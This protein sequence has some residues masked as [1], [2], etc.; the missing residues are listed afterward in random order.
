MISAAITTVEEDGVGGLSVA[1][2][3]SGARVSR[4]TF[5][6]I[7]EDAEDCFLACF[8]QSV[9]RA[10]QI[11]R[12]AY[13]TGSDWRSSTRAAV[14]GLLGAMERQRALTRLCIV[15]VLAGGPR[16]L[17]RRAQILETV[18]GALA[19]GAQS[20]DRTRAVDP[21]AAQAIAGAVAELLLARELSEDDVPST[22]LTGP[23]M[24]MIVLPYLGRSIACEE[25]RAS[26]SGYSSVVASEEPSSK[27]AGALAGL[28]IRLTY[29]TVRVLI[30]VAE[31]PDASNR[32]V[33]F[34]AGIVD[35]GQVSKLLKRLARLGLIENGGRGQLRGA[36][37]AWRLTALGVDVHRATRG[38]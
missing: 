1:R 9:T 25:L 15:D 24:S 34:H 10:S 6:D 37:N 18:A 36:S 19:Q 38:L 29:R 32:E 12:A 7:F 27:Q 3:I 23:I 26:G 35:Q 17:E 33:A 20:I 11:V 4:R 14:H 8:E 5:Y 2:I 28:R 13:A 16:L 22:D 31:I 21:L 30:A